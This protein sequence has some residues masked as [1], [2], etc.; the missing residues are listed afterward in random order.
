MALLPSLDW[1]GPSG[2]HTPLRTYLRSL[3]ATEQCG[4]AR[5]E[6]FYPCLRDLLLD[7]AERT[8]RRGAAVTVIPRKTA[9][10][11]LDF[12]VWSGPHQVAGYV[13]AKRPGTD[14]DRAA[15]S[16]QVRRYLATFPNL[17]LTDFYE[18]RLYRNGQAAG[19][20]GVGWG[21]D[22]RPGGGED[23]ARLLDDFFAFCT[24]GL[25][26]YASLATALA[27]R[28][29]VLAARIEERLLREEA[30]EARTRLTG[31]FE[32]FKTFLLSGLTVREFADLYAQTV[33][34]GLLAARWHA[35]ESFDPHSAFANIPLGSGILREVF[36]Y[37][38]LGSPPPEIDWII[39]DLTGL[40][41][42]SSIFGRR[43]WDVYEDKHR[44]PVHHFYETFLA[45]YNRELRAR[46]GVYYTPLPVVAWIVR[47]VHWLLQTRFSRPG[48]L[49]DPS[50]TLLDPA[51]GTMTFVA[52]ACRVAVDAHRRAAGSGGVPALLR[53]HLLPHFQAF[54]LMMAPYAIG[55]LKMSL[56]LEQHGYRLADGE[57]VHLYLADALRQDDPP[58]TSLP[59]VDALAQEA[60][61][62][63]R[64]KS[65]ERIFVVLG[66]P[67]WSGTSANRG[68]WIQDLLKGYTLPDG[69]RDEGYYRADGRP[70]GERNPKWLQ[71][72]YVKFLRFAQWK[73]DQNGEGI[74]A[75][76]TNHGW[77]DNPTFRGMRQ[78]LLRT[79]DE[80]FVLDLHGNR[81]KG[82][83]RP[84]GQP[85]DNVF[86][87]IE[88][89]VA[90]TLLVKKPGL[91]KRILRADLWG[92]RL[93]K[94]RWLDTTSAQTTLW[95]LLSPSSHLLVA[96]DAGIEE[97]YRR[98]VPLPEI[99]PIHSVGIVTGR[100]AAVT[101][102]DRAELMERVRSLR[103]A[104]WRGGPIDPAWKLDAAAMD[105]ARRDGLWERRFTP[106]LPRPF[107]RRWLFYADYLVER[108]REA[109]MRHLRGGGNLALIAPR[110]HKEEPGALV[111]DR[112]AGHKAVSAYDINYVFPLWLD[113]PQG[114]I[115]QSRIDGR[116]P[117]LAPGLLCRLAEVLGEEPAP[118]DVLGYV[119]AVLYSPSY[120][121]RYADLLRRDFPRIPFPEERE[122][123]LRLAALGREL[124][125]LHLLT[126]PR[127]DGS[128]VRFVGDGGRPLGKT[129][130][131]LRHY[132]PDERRV[133]VNAEG[134]CFE[135]IEP[136]V[137]SYQL[138]GHQV[139]DRWL[140]GR[141]GRVLGLEEIRDFRRAA[142][143]LR[144]T[145]EV[146][147]R[148]DEV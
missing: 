124:V 131:T 87:D 98:G 72:D 105:R 120:R 10:C 14:L 88:Q 57:R 32:A 128:P 129:R 17:I 26:S 73:I 21:E 138:G 51:A 123:F 74:V 111:T 90:I 147:R 100:D 2:E 38:T 5:E 8:G 67:P 40:L 79:F 29:R 48:G 44:D 135:G 22:G 43:A 126:D 45:S 95:A 54:E 50:V 99:F 42:G 49:A 33:T 70:L 66:N 94:R 102:C 127:L 1:E 106:Y 130:A 55:H 118:E 23:L 77:L 12:Q 39:G 116:V 15:Q 107:D 9:E 109:V 85:D 104:L 65:E 103:C 140:Q 80:V 78:S 58:Q 76:V 61:A 141:A 96:S 62:A 69:S 18:L 101:G 119:Y 148:I 139:L 7:H 108:P 64:I 71:D 82:E 59:Y 91:P 20:A 41:G 30:G 35:P 92:N 83:R 132:R 63:A 52:E 28:A 34:Y 117:N 13:E 122:P 97:E 136:A 37:I 143:A 134:L 75:F 16:A 115:G 25:R 114:T 47:S 113:P 68:A 137:W 81:R 27:G 36:Q 3:A 145:L 144:L 6:S 24:P 142:E 125:G 4:D 121:T 84:D 46:R 19:Q 110:Q 112:I 31:F 11:L 133:Y 53:D 93:W 56:F 146:Q 86:D 89:G 60:Q